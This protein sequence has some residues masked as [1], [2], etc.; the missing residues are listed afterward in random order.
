MVNVV[1]GTGVFVETEE[2]CTGEK[3]SFES[4]ESII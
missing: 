4:F 1:L 2:V 3:E